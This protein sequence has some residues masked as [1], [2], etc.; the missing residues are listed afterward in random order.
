MR[1]LGIDAALACCSAAVLDTGPDARVLARSSRP[2]DRGHSAVLAGMV[3]EVLAGAGLAAGA[4]DG[5]AVT[6]GP[7]SFTGL[8]AALSLGHGLALAAGI[9]IVGVTV[10]EA[11]AAAATDLGGR[12]LWVATGSRRDRVFLCRDGV[13]TAW[14]LAALPA[15]VGRVAVA[16]D[17]A[18]EVA[19]RLL[20]R[21]GDVKLSGLRLPD[22]AY[23][24]AVGARR[25]AGLLPPL[26]A[27]PLYVDEPMARLPAGGL[28]TA[29]LDG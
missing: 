8:R 23:V 26:K 28:R 4:L 27:M 22:P 18:N 13:L 10:A 21:G 14:E 25:L 11:L 29:P 16:G 12:D 9:P 17:A 7:G 1:V 24:A 2:G 3:A 6:V 19:A 5:V 15:A 20:A